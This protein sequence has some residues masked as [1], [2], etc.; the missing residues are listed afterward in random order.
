MKTKLVAAFIV[1]AGAPAGAHRLDEYLQ[2]T[3]I[4]IDK[5]EIRAEIR[6]TPGIAVFPSVLGTID[7]DS[8]GVISQREGRAYADRVLHDLSLTIDGR[9][10]PLRLVSTKFPEIQD[11]K[12]GLGEI[13]I[14]FT[15]S[16]PDAGRRR[17][18]IFE[19]RHQSAIAAY[20]VNCLIPRDPD[21]RIVAQNRNYQQ[22]FYQ[23][24][25]EQ[26]RAVPPLG[27]ALVGVIAIG[28]FARLAMFWRRKPPQRARSTEKSY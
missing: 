27:R 10:L 5:D 6:L 24:D 1:V 8:D 14:E 25:Y 11:M 4:S 3:L 15:A 17:K 16:L 22:S 2:A 19:N 13:H 7:T 18:L 28:L 9:G 12:E 21:I 23:L 26:A 20:L